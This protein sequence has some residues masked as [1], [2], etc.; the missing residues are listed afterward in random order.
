MDWK[1]ARRSDNVEIDC[2]GLRTNINSP[3]ADAAL[4]CQA[5]VTAL[6][7]KYTTPSGIGA[8]I[9]F[10]SSAVSSETF[11]DDLTK[12]MGTGKQHSEPLAGLYIESF[13][14]GPSAASELGLVD[15]PKLFEIQSSDLRKA[16]KKSHKW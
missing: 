2:L 5:E 3:A 9:P 12:F 7:E 15:D 1:N 10:L 4:A 6:R 14:L 11:Q 16:L 13:M 8:W